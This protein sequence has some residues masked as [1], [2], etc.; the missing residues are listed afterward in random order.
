MTDPLYWISFALLCVYL[1]IMIHAWRTTRRPTYRQ[2][3]NI[4]RANPAR[5]YF[6]GDRDQI[7]ADWQTLRQLLPPAGQP[8]ASMLERDHLRAKAFLA[9]HETVQPLGLGQPEQQGGEVIPLHPGHSI[10]A[11]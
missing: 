10:N 1:A 2:R 11:S 7:L 3:I 6:A 5:D 8:L 9:L 4:A